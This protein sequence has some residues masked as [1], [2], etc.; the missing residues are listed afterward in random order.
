MLKEFK[1]FIMKGNVVD[2]AIG[3]V[4]GGAFGAIITALVEGIINPIIGAATAGIAMDH[5][6]VKLGQVELVYGM[7]LSALLKFIIIGFILFIIV[8]SLNKMRKQEEAAPTTK[9]CPH[10]MSEIDIN[11][12]RCPHCTSELAAK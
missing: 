11:A 8:K 7:F 12:S 10:C 6:S 9:V 3:V 5:M 1:E 4:L 2:L